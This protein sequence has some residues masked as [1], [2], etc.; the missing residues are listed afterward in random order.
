MVDVERMIMAVKAF[1]GDD[2]DRNVGVDVLD[3]ANEHRAQVEV[4]GL[5][6]D[7]DPEIARCHQRLCRA[8]SFETTT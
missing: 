6:E 8:G 5:G 2:H 4:A 1:A 7:V 3:A